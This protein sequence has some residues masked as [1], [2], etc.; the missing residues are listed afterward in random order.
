MKYL[1]HYSRTLA[2]IQGKTFNMNNR[3][4]FIAQRLFQISH[5][6]RESH[7][8]STANYYFKR[9]KQRYGGQ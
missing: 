2:M 3:T 7:K 5:E 4:W 1:V 6:Y 9:I 8:I